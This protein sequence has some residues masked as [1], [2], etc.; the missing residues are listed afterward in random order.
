MY[1]IISNLSSFRHCCKERTQ[2]VTRQSTSIRTIRQTPYNSSLRERN[3]F[4]LM[5]VVRL[6][7]T[8]VAHIGIRSPGFA[9]LTR[10]EFRSSQR[11]VRV[12]FA[13]SFGCCGLLRYSLTLVPRKDGCVRFLPLSVGC[14]GLLRCP[15]AA[16]ASQR[17]VCEA[18][19]VIVRLLWIASL[20]ADA[21]SSQRR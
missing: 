15:P 17:R 20:L 14:C 4:M 6:G 3:S 16:D 7:L 2:S 13:V 12:V 9:T 19:A 21:R 1:G 11:R 10:P 5:P 18:L 8:P